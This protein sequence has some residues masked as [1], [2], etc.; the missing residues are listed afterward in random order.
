MHTVSP[1]ALTTV[2]KENHVQSEFTQ[3]LNE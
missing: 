1:V 2:Y 3:T